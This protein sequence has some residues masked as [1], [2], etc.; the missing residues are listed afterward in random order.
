MNV[1]LMYLMRAYVASRKPNKTDERIM[2]KRLSGKNDLLVD[3]GGNV[4]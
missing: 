3:G 2:M 4:L 1:Q